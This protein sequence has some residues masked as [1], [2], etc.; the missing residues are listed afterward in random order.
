M[1][2]SDNPEYPHSPIEGL[3]FYGRLVTRCVCCLEPY[4][5]RTQQVHARHA[6]LELAAYFARY[7]PPPDTRD[8]AHAGAIAATVA[9]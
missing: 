2:L 7:F 5:C 6:A 4:P 9:A 8:Y 3:D 1:S